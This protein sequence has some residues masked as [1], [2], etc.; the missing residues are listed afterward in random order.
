MVG[1]DILAIGA[2]A[3]FSAGG[4]YALVNHRLTNLDDNI[5]ALQKD[6]KEHNTNLVR[7]QTDVA[8]IKGQQN[9][10]GV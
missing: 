3:V 4:F 9:S 10:G 5:K 1:P 2:T 7:V 6:F 8:Y